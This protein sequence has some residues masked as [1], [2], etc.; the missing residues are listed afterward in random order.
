MLGCPWIA[1]VKQGGSYRNR[2]FKPSQTLSQDQKRPQTEGRCFFVDRLHHS[3]SAAVDLRVVGGGRRTDH[4]CIQCASCTGICCPVPP[5]LANVIESM[6]VPHFVVL[7]IARIC[8]T[9]IKRAICAGTWP[10]RRALRPR[11]VLQTALLP[12]RR[13]LRK[14][15]SRWEFGQAS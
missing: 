10:R 1:Q 13:Q 4:V 5:L 2:A 8:P 6:P 11:N 14:E 9:W 3:R 7:R 15:L 12:Q